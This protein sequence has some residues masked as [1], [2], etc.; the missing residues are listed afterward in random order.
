MA[1]SM[2]HFDKAAADWD[3]EPRRIALMRAIGEAILREAA[4]TRET[5]VL[6]YG[7]GTGLV[8]LFLLPH[9]SSVTGADNSPG[10]LEVLR[11]KIAESGLTN[12]KVILL[13]LQKDPI[14]ADRFQMIVVA[15]AMHHIADTEGVLR[16]F[17]DLLLPG[18]TLCLADLD[19]EPGNFHSPEMAHV[20]HHHGFDRQELKGQLAEAGFAE[21]KDATALKF[22]KPVTGQGEREFS[23]FLM[24]SRRP[25]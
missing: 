12:M 4:P 7:C 21:M 3:K 10:M 6:D 15:M 1:E 18:G 8:G 22:N 11:A 20:V 19:T 25:S 13:D 23:V 24:C 17:Y 2:T 5:D 14:P 16:A 9:V